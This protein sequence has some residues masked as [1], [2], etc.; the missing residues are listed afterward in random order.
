MKE[1]EEAKVL[2]G[3]HGVGMVRGDPAHNGMDPEG[4][5]TSASNLNSSAQ[6]QNKYFLGWPKTELAP[7]PYLSQRT[8]SV[9]TEERLRE[10]NKMFSKLGHLTL[11]SP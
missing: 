8:R 4:A 7:S 2:V 9:F 5:R 10:L 3:P 6:L 1:H 11:S